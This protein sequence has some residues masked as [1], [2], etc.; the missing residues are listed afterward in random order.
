MA[1]RKRGMGD[2]LKIYLPIVLV[3]VAGFVFTWQFVDPAPPKAITI[4]TGMAEGTYAEFGAKYR[5]ALAES[6]ID[7]TVRHTAGAGENI[8]LLN[9]PKGGVE[10]AFIQGGI[11]DPFGAPRLRSVASVFFEPLW[12]FVR[13]TGAMPD[14]LSALRGKRI[15]VGVAGSGTRVLAKTLLVANDVDDE[16]S[17]FVSVGG[18][19]AAQALDD[20]RLDAAFFVS[21][22]LSQRLLA[23]LQKPEIRLMGLAHADAYQRRYKY[24][25]GIALPEGVLDLGANLPAAPVSTVAPTAALVVR[26]DLHPALVD[27]LL[28]AASRIHAEGN[29]TT[30]AGLFPSPRYV[31]FPL[32]SDAE[33][34]FKSGPTFLRR[35]L[36]FEAAIMVERLMIMLVPLVTLLIPMF[37]LAPPAY[38]WGIRRKIYR[39]YRELREIEGQWRGQAD[40]ADPGGLI[41][42]L[43]EIQTQ[44]GQLH[45]PLSYAEQLYHLRLHIAFVRQVVSGDFAGGGAI[46]EP[47]AERP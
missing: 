38:R 16:N 12:V 31:D 19:D 39:W 45:I 43:D 24:L 17:T 1:K 40:A 30:P 2:F 8:A 25:S 33:R 32:S 21:G 28:G 22:T 44:V 26:E 37:K 6:G 9:D 35:V 3:V 47:T 10:V 15:G 36:P 11:G 46:S 20:G 34:Y 13:G 42:R 5:K 29:L 7:L 4:A 23:L 27:L 41:R 14:R 18:N